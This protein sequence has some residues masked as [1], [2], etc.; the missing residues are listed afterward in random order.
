[1][2][3]GCERVHELHAS[4]DPDCL[5]KVHC[6][7]ELV[8][9]T[10]PDVSGTD[11]TMFEI[12]VIEIAAN[13]IEHG[14]PGAITNCDLTIEVHPHRLGANFRDDGIIAI[15]N[16]DTAAMPDLLAERGRGLAIAKAALDV[17]TYERRNS[18]N[19]W[20]LSR[21]RTTG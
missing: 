17:L 3:R 9:A 11:R 13:I 8:W 20:T 18:T 15:V 2:S 19:F 14:S 5:E 4:A 7:L 10:S 1:M 16:I 12:A 6:L 21:T